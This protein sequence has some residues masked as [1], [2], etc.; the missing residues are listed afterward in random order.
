MQMNYSYQTPKG[1]PGGLADIAPYA[2][3]SRLNGESEAG[4]LKFGMGAVYGDDP[5][6]TVAVPDST[7]VSNKFEGVVLTSFTQ[8]QALEGGVKIYPKQT[9]GIL[10]YGYAWARVAPDITISYGDKLYLIT[11]GDNAGLFTND[12]NDGMA[13]NGRFVDDVDNGTI[14]MVEIFNS[15]AV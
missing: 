15:P 8:Q 6:K 13:V 11:D 5:G 1:V 10:R 14:A 12:D 2:I 3:N 9:V 4:I 7:A